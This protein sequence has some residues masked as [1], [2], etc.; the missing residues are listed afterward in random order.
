MTILK[1]G[2]FKVSDYRKAI[3]AMT[4]VVCVL[5]QDGKCSCGK[6][7]EG[8]NIDF[9]HDPALNQ[10]DYD[11]DAGDFIPPQND[12][13]HM[14]ARHADCHKVKTFGPGGEKRIHTR[15]SDRSEP[16]RLDKIRERHEAHTARIAAPIGR[17]DSTEAQGGSLVVVGTLNDAGVEFVR[18]LLRPSPRREQPKT[19]WPSRPFRGKAKKRKAK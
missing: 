6:K 2:T 3:P 15:G 5:N 11:T 17:I 1:A 8:D 12:T 18:N 9:D 14:R 10:R 7:L 19:K 16:G 4:K 13:A